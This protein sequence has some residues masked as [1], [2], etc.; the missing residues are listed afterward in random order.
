[1]FVLKVKL[2]PSKRM[3][4]ICG[5]VIAAIVIICV[6]CTVSAAG[7]MPDTATC[8]EGGEYSLS[9]SNEQE[10]L[11][12]LGNFGLDADRLVSADII[13][14]PSEFNSVY[15]AYNDL[16]RQIGLDLSRYKGES[17]ERYMYALNGENA[18]SAVILVRNN[19]VIG[20]HITSGEF[21]EENRPL[22]E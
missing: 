4:L 6:I 17:A 13:T 1:M 15:K 7:R 10:R 9:A 20:G 18:D 12:F 11:E 3:F 14:I 16:Q 2:K 5:A 22:N 21:G 19:R 8:D